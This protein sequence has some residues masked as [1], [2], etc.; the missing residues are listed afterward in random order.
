MTRESAENPRD[1][2]TLPRLG[3][4]DITPDE[5]N[6][7]PPL[8]T[9][10]SVPES[11]SNPIQPDG[12]T[13]HSPSRTPSPHSQA[14]TDR[15]RSGLFPF[16]IRFLLVAAALLLIAG[17]FLASRLEPSARGYGTHQQLGLPPCSIQLLFGIPC[18][19]CGMTTSFAW[20]VR[21]QLMP[22]WQANPAGLYLAIA[23]TLLIPWLMWMAIRPR[24]LTYRTFERMSLI[25]F[26]PFLLFALVQWAVRAW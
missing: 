10:R 7:P 4:A 14:T 16:L 21:G 23:C 8:S 5:I 26:G 3:S 25:L 6:S 11:T 20:Y 24:L 19:S 13:A 17:F 22:A 12:L 18:P 1:E 9:G 2:E 15:S